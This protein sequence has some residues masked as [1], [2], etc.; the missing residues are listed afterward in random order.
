MSGAAAW[1]TVAK[2]DVSIIDI[3]EA[4]IADGD[5]MGISSEILQHVFRAGQWRLEVHHPW[6]LAQRPD[7]RGPPRMFSELIRQSQCIVLSQGVQSIAILGSKHPRQRLHGKQKAALCGL[8]WGRCHQRSIYVRRR[9]ARAPSSTRL[10]DR[11][12]VRVPSQHHRIRSATARAAIRSALS[13][14]PAP[15]YRAA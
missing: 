7:Q 8:R 5:A 6:L 9:V 10:R 3:D 11:C 12:R 1:W 4:L 2:A 15:C 13:A 14:E